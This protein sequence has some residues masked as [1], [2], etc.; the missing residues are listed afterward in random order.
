[1]TAAR[2]SPVVLAVDFGTT[3]TVGVARWGHRRPS[4][5]VVDGAPS[6]PSAVLLGHDGS[7][8]VGQD[9][10]RLGRAA[11]ARLEPRPKS[12]LDEDAV[13]LGDRT[14]DVLDAVRAVLARLC[15][16]VAN[17]AG[18]PVEHLVL[19]HPADWGAVRLARAATGLAARTSLVPE[20]VAAAAAGLPAGGTRA[21]LDFGGGT[22][23][24]A[25][26][27]AAGPD[28]APGN[29]VLACAGL[30]D[31]GGDDL[32]QRIVDF[33]LGRSPS[34]AGRLAGIVSTQDI[35]VLRDRLLLREDARTAKELLSRHDLARVA[36]PGLDEPVVVRRAD[37]ERIVAADLERAATLL[38][39][40][41]D[42][43][44][45]PV[46]EVLL[47]GGSSRIP[48]LGELPRDR[49]DVPVTNAREPE[50]MAA[51]GA[52]AVTG[53]TE[54]TAAHPVALAASAPVASA[55]VRVP[56]PA[57]APPAGRGRRRWPSC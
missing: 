48:A 5:V 6:M 49:L 11:A 42:T 25:V 56:V 47:V 41:L 40:V 46:D 2:G 57:A 24:A 23:D 38:A 29:S 20:P 54:P 45:V 1:M 9:A 43:A 17:Q 35:K 22:C 12:R 30:S 8:I 34:A 10:L 36:V 3:N 7:L 39:G 16:E 55:P 21:V 19:T 26:V 14:V 52:L 13:L 31:L 18:T 51:F 4:Q 27:R 44:G 28:A 53:S 32:D 37:F 15:G 33:V 50:P